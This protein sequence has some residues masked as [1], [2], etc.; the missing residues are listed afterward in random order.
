MAVDDNHREEKD[1][2]GVGQAQLW[3]PVSVPKQPAFA[4]AAYNA[5]LLAGLEAFEPRV[6]RPSRNFPSGA[7]KQRGL[8]AWI[9]SPSCD[10][11]WPNTPKCSHPS[12]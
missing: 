6:D 10:S 8:P 11:K 4:V 7:A 9:W 1:T 2:V 12:A 5:L 3:N